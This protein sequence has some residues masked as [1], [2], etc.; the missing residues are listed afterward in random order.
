MYI[1]VVN[2]LGQSEEVS[3]FLLFELLTNNIDTSNL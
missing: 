3:S 1:S 2:E